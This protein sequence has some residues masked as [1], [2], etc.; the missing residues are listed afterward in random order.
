ME[1]FIEDNLQRMYRAR[2]DGR[3]EYRK[4]VWRV[5]IKDYFQQFVRIGDVVLDL[6]AGY[7]EFIN[8]IRCD[9]KY[10][11]DLNPDTLQKASSDVEVIL[12]DCSKPWP[13][14][15][16]SLDVV[17]TSNFFEHLP[18]KHVLART[19]SEAKRCI[20][21]N[22]RIIAMGPNI[23]YVSGAYWDFIDHHIPL[24]E[25]S[26][27]EVLTHQGFQIEKCIDKFLPYTMASGPQYPIIFLATYLRTPI[28]WRIFGKQFLVIARKSA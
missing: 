8:Q 7:G 24:T 25:Q 18:D 16:N 9:K 28:A 1:M 23:K 2:F 14:P 26:L 6:G 22:G 4:K 17:F 13:L 12:H 11:L 27:S 3:L 20:K 19:I 10:A 5:L 21:P 15:N